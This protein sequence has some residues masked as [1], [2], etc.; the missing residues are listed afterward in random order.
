MSRQQ[1]AFSKEFSKIKGCGSLREDFCTKFKPI[2]CDLGCD[3][4]KKRDTSKGQFRGVG[5]RLGVV[6]FYF[7]RYELKYDVLE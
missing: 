1:V 7:M 5:G 4:V 6:L 3:M 2:L